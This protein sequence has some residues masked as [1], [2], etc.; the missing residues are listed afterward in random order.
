MRVR[1]G[2]ANARF[3]EAGRKYIFALLPPG[4]MPLINCDLAQ[5]PIA[6]ERDGLR[7]KIETREPEENTHLVGQR[8]DVNHDLG[9]EW[10]R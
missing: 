5:S 1:V 8:R 2:S 7:C 3:V 4:M 9:G 10:R 6:K